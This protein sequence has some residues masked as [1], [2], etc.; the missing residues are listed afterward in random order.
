M[1]L[2][3]QL[4]AVESRINMKGAKKISIIKCEWQKLMYKIC[5]KIGK[6]IILIYYKVAKFCIITYL[7]RF[8]PK[9]VVKTI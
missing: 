1:L 9:L 7:K 8:S 4:F 3:K 6:N 2:P 5:N